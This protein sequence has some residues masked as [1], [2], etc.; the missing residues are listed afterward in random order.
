LDVSGRVVKELVA[1]EKRA[2][3][4]SRDNLG[5]GTYFV[6]VSLSAGE[7]NKKIVLQ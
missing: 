4:I 3:E 6:K 5:S 7:V 1:T 2:Y